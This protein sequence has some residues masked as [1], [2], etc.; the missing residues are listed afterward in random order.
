[1]DSEVL[2][3]LTGLLVALT[4]LLALVLR[5]PAPAEPEPEEPETTTAPRVPVARDS[6]PA[7]S[8]RFIRRVL[9]VDDDPAV[10]SALRRLLAQELPHVAIDEA[11]DGV[12]AIESLAERPCDLLVIDVCMSGTSGP[13]VVRHLRAVWPARRT[14]VILY[15]ALPVDALEMLRADVDADAAIEKGTDA[16][17]LADVVRKL[18]VI[19]PGARGAPGSTP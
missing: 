4:G 3:A 9:L 16:G 7:P 13:E 12:G 2:T 6:E 17:A 10:T 5:R 11:H 15:S 14:P 19:S 18:L 8:S 1:M